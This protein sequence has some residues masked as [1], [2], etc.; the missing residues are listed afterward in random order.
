MMMVDVER[1][2]A[3]GV[4]LAKKLAELDKGP[5]E[6]RETEGEHMVASEDLFDR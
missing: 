3:E 1:G 6:E 4:A 2:R 5:E